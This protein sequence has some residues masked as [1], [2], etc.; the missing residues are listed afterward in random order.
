MVLEIVEVF[1]Q[2]MGLLILSLSKE[3]SFMSGN[4]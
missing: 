4:S 2:C 1:K 3:H